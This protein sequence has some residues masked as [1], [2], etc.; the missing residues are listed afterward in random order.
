MAVV[1][2]MLT[3]VIGFAAAFTA[4]YEFHNLAQEAV[5]T[6]LQFGNSAY[7]IHR[8]HVSQAIAVMAA[9]IMAF[10]TIVLGL[11]LLRGRSGARVL[12]WVF[13]A[14]MF[15]GG[16]TIDAAWLIDGDEVHLHGAL[17]LAE[18]GLT[19]VAYASIMV[20]LATPES[21]RF[22]AATP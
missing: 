4:V 18:C 21:S 19:V 8:L 9:A 2:M 3:V 6:Q 15:L 11:F 22:F 13:C 16:I 1:L 17:L 14:A 20:L 7:S 5:D 12:T 10:Y